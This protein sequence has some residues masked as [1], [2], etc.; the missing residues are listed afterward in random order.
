MDFFT[1]TGK[2]ALG[3]RLRRLGERFMMEAEKIYVLYGIDLN[4]RWF[5]VYYM[6]LEQ[7]GL[8]TTE[9]ARMIGQSHASVSQVVKEMGKKG[10]IQTAKS[11]ADGR[12][13]I[14]SLTEQ[15]REMVNQARIQFV[16]VN[17]AVEDLIAETQ[18]DLWKAMEEME[19]MLD[20]ED[21]YSRVRKVRKERES[22]AVEILDYEPQYASDF[23]DINYTWIEQNFCVEDSDRQILD[24]PDE[25][26]MKPGGHI[27]MARYDG[28]IVGACALIKVNETTFELAKMGVVEKARGKNVGWLLGKACLE[29]ARELGAKKV[30]LESN[31]KLAP[32]INLYHKLGFQKITGHPSPY[33][34]CNIQMEIAL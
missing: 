15:A 33:T 13:N 7:D 26:I 23:R 29:K 12:T 25:H 32:A 21:F 2:L 9:I 14:I 22:A 10:V 30:H 19:F 5:P 28:E 6:L 20:Q 31:T 18:Y 27:Y 4:P 8:S 17:Q 34:R 1:Q 16:D 24:H 3:S 11:Q